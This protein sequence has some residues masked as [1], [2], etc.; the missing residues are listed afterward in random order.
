[1]QNALLPSRYSLLDLSPSPTV[2]LTRILQAI[3]QKFKLQ[4]CWNQTVKHVAKIRRN[5]LVKDKVQLWPEL[6]YA[7][8]DL[9][10]LDWLGSKNSF[11]GDIQTYFAMLTLPITGIAAS[12]SLITIVSKGIHLLQSIPYHFTQWL[13]SLS[14][15][16]SSIKMNIHTTAVEC[17]EGS[18]V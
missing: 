18:S 1:M 9:T 11:T 14:I 3:F 15:L 2:F 8:H 12:A 4:G 17:V 6:C 7:G 5:H 16:A 10:R 13:S